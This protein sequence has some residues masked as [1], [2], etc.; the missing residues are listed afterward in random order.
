[1]RG[2]YIK[3]FYTPHQHFFHPLTP[4][5]SLLSLSLPSLPPPF[6]P[7]PPLSPS[8][9]PPLQILYEQQVSSL[10]EQ[11]ETKYGCGFQLQSTSNV[12]QGSGA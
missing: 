7:P 3:N 1:M 8:S 10:K 4:L 12:P 2:G 9:L 6:L 11:L 5:P